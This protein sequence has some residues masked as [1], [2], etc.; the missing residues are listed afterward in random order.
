MIDVLG[1]KAVQDLGPQTEKELYE[2]LRNYLGSTVLI[3][4]K[5]I[6]RAGQLV[7][8]SY[9]REDEQIFYSVGGADE[10]EPVCLK[11]HIEVRL[12]G[13]WKTINRGSSTNEVL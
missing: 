10:R 6:E 2:L 13:G 7:R 1:Q 11:Q 3:R 12:D 5:A 9:R 8:V 4:H